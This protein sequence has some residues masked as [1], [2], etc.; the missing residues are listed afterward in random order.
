MSESNIDATVD[1]D[2]QESNEPISMDD[3]IRD[4]LK[5]LQSRGESEDSPVEAPPK[6]AAPV[7]ARDEAGK[8]SK[9]VI[10]ADPV[11]PSE[12]PVQELR[13]PN[14]W[15]KEAQE[16][17][18]KADPIIRAEVERREA[19]F[20]RGIDQYRQAADWAHKI[21]QSL[22][23]YKATFEKLGITPDVAIAGLAGADHKLR[24]GSPQE[25][26]EYFSYLAKVY[27]IDLGHTAQ[28]AGAID[29]R[30]YQLQEENQ[31]LQ[32][33]FQYQQQQAQQQEYDALNSEINA[34]AAD[35]NHS[36]F[37]AVRGHMIALLQADQ[38]KDLKDAYEQAIYANPT[39]RAAVLQQQAAAARNEASKKAQTA[40][41][42]SSVN[43]RSRPALATSQ[44][45]GTMDDT[46]RNEYR[47]LSG[48]YS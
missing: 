35:P 24:Y 16:A 39:T 23:P 40:K 6:E 26:A 44:P 4:T 48:D 15:K 28:V 38:A 9:A 2:A 41:A 3:T 7:R 27:S 32:Q 30:I 43:M 37:E 45:I 5:E 17:F 29:P 34:F 1:I 22:T 42:A 13:A 18:I 33:T 14:T 19:D 46:I 11:E 25:K 20:H 12:A 31:R 36:H 47:R 8:F 10:E 21:D